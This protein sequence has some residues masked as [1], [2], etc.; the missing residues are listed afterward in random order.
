MA[1]NF[2]EIRVSDGSTFGEGTNNDA[3]L[4]FPKTHVSQ[5]VDLLDSNNKIDIG[6]LPAFMFG[7]PKYLNTITTGATLKGLVTQM[8]E[9]ANELGMENLTLLYGLYFQAATTLSFDFDETINVNSGDEPQLENFFGTTLL[10]FSHS[11]DDGVVGTSDLT[12]EANDYLVFSNQTE[13]NSGEINLHFSVINN[14]YNDASTSLKGVVQLATE[15][16]ITAGTNTTK[17]VTPAG[18]KK[19]VQQFGYTHPSIAI[20]DGANIGLLSNLRTITSIGLSADGNHIEYIATAKI[21]TADTGNEGVVKL[22][23]ETEAKSEILFPY[24]EGYAVSPLVAKAMI[25]YWGKVDYFTTL[26]E[27]NE[28][29]TK[30]VAGKMI[31]VGV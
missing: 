23:T 28:S 31:L 4:Y 30:N 24:A 12:I 27:A 29:P 3:Q 18:A 17:A 19:A 1:A 9:K 26:A 7:S 22:A 21:P 14:T 2:I 20:N 15:A 16:E 5:V 11:G 10:T 25:D 13:P 8:V 6:L